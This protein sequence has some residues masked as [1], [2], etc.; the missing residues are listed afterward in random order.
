MKRNQKAYG[1]LRQL[2]EGESGDNGG[3]EDNPA[4]DNPAEDNQ[5]KDDPAK[6][7]SDDDLDKIISKK[8]AE[9]QKKQQKAVDQA[10][11]LAEMNAEERAKHERDELQKEL[12]ELKKANAVNEL[13]REARKMLTAEGINAPDDLVKNLIGDDADATKAAITAFSKMYK[14]AVQAGIKDALKGKTPK[15]GGDAT[16]TK[17]E[18]MKI[19]DRNERQKM[20]SEHIDLFRK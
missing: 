16:I 12:D 2:F 19:A 6:K 20:I 7:Y 11:K 10:K 14:A 4:E 3:R 9:W 15:G 5:G 8:F 17:E 18:I 1:Y 13:Q